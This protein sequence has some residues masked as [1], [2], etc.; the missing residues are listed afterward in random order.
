MPTH[1]VTAGR[2]KTPIQCL[3]VDEQLFELCGAA[4]HIVALVVDGGS[5]HPLK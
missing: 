4:W 1:L 2:I 5:F 3:A